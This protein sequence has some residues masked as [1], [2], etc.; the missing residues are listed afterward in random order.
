[1]LKLGDK[2]ER[3][4]GYQMA[5]GMN[6]GDRG[7]VIASKMVANEEY[8]KLKEYPNGWH[9][10]KLLEKQ[11]TLKIDTSNIDLHKIAENILVAMNKEEDKRNLGRHQNLNKIETLKKQRDKIDKQIQELENKE[12]KLDD[13]YIEKIYKKNEN[14]L[15]D[16]NLYQKGNTITCL[17]TNPV[18]DKILGKGISKCFPGDKFDMNIGC[19]IAFS[20]AVMSYNNRRV[21]ELIRSTY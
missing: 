17:L 2:V 18:T 11:T 15:V 3:I 5:S 21:H 12:V 4:K 7:T 8:V 16:A 10:A 6:I 14:K 1:M 20:R 13:K 19:E 9:S